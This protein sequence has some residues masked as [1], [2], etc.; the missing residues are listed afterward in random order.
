MVA[1]CGMDLVCCLFRLCCGLLS[2][3]FVCC[4]LGFGFGFV[5][6]WL[7]GAVVGLND[8]D[9]LTVNGMFFTLLSILLMLCFVRCF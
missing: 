6:Y 4:V 3:V 9:G 8:Y 5:W 1:L 2:L 7:C